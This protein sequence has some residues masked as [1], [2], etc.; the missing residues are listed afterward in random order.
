MEHR[1]VNANFVKIPNL[2]PVLTTCSCIR[3]KSC[4]K[5]TLASTNVTMIP[6]ILRVGRPL[7]R[8]PRPNLWSHRGQP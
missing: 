5:G 1:T 7:V 6:L 4:N 2:L 3:Q 8:E